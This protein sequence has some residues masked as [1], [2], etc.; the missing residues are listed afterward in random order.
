MMP[1]DE[2]KTA[3]R[4]NLRTLLGFAMVLFSIYRLLVLLPT[5]PDLFANGDSTNLLAFGVLP[6]LIVVVFFFGGMR[7][8]R[9]GYYGIE[10][11]KRE[12]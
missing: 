6:A 11:P 3:N 8:A 12:E 5:L 2:A 9:Q 4:S 1:I 10:K 7:I